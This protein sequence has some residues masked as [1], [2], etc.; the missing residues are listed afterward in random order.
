MTIQEQAIAESRSAARDTIE[1]FEP[2]TRAPLGRVRVDTPADVRGAVERAREAQRAWGASS[3]A[4]RRSVL[5]HILDHLLAHA[6]ELCEM[7]VRDAGKTRENAVMGE[8]W[9]VAEKL[10]W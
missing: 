3:F 2:A 8:I 5:T 6:D 1:C 9:P 10:R 7:I 4:T